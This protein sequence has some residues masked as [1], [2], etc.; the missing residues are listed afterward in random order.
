LPEAA[1]RVAGED[2]PALE[3]LP[4]DDRPG[5]LVLDGFVGRS[6]PSSVKATDDT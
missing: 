1:R 2:E 4:V 3:V 5:D 6:S